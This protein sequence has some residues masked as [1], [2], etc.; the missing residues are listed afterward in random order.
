LCNAGLNKVPQKEREKAKKFKEYE[1]G[2]LHIDV[3]CCPKLDGVKWDLFV[4]IDRA[5]RAFINSMM[6][7]LLKM[8]RTLWSNGKQFTLLI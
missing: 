3:T 4:A 2:Y 5:V 7:K 1:P 6:L 8:Q